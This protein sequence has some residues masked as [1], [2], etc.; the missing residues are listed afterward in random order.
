MEVLIGIAAFFA[1]FVTDVIWARYTRHVADGNRHRASV[2]AALIIFTA[3]GGWFAY[4]TT[5]W[6]AVPMA[7]GAYLGTFFAIRPQGPG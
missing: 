6:N 4:H 3:A 1:S 7:A 5:L 2:M